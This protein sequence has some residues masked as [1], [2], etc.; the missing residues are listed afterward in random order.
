VRDE[1][2]DLLASGF[3]K[4]FDPTEVSRVR[5]DQGGVELMLTNNL[6]KLITDCPSDVVPAGRLRRELLGLSTRGV[7]RLGQGTDLLDGADADSVSLPQSSV[8]GASFSDA[9]FC[10]VDEKRNIGGIRIAITDKAPT[11]SGFVNSSSE[12][13][14]ICGCIAEFLRRRHADAG[15]PFSGCELQESCVCYVPSTLN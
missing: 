2:F 1:A 12:C 7:R 13:P 11:G 9:H 10:A 3:T 6:A 5:L 15:T 4:S 8:D 14:A